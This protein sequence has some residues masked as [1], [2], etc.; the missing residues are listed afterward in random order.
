MKHLKYNDIN[1]KRFE[2]LNAPKKV[3][4]QYN[5]KIKFFPV[6]CDGKKYKEIEKNFIKD[7]YFWI[8]ATGCSK[9]LNR[10]VSSIRNK[11]SELKIKSS[12]EFSKLNGMKDYSYENFIKHP[13]KNTS[14]ILGLLWADGTILGNGN[15]IQIS[16]VKEDFE[17]V[18]HI[19]KE[20]ADWIY[21]EVNKS[22]NR[23]SQT[24]ATINDILFYDFLNLMDYGIKS[25]GIGP[26]K[27]LSFLGEELHSHFVR[28][29]FDGDGSFFSYKKRICDNHATFTSGAEE[30]WEELSN[31]LNKLKIKFSIS[32]TKHNSHIVISN[33]NGF[34]KLYEYM[35]KNSNTAY[36]DRKK[37][38]FIEYFEKIQKTKDNQHSQYRGVSKIKR[39]KGITWVMQFRS[40]LAPKRITKY[41][42]KE[43][44][45]AREYDRLA[46]KYIGEKAHLNFNE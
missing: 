7:F 6:S 12:P 2:V 13:N 33:Q 23:K 27:I 29:W 42:K 39:K 3:I 15:S 24:R 18:E 34:R 4:N 44:D 20:E 46:L 9:I 10:S 1:H 36:L 14:Y 31:I 37:R 8:G 28:G 32:R 19:F 16:I 25:N 41:F 40:N 38:A 5:H 45:A 11:A 22:G 17:K 30:N 21:Y 35:Y 43:L 26:S